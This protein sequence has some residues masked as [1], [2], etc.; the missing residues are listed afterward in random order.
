MRPLYDPRKQE[1]PLADGRLDAAFLR[2]L[3][4]D[5][6]W[7]VRCRRW[8]ANDPYEKTVV[9]RSQLIEVLL[10]DGP[11]YAPVQQGFHHLGLLC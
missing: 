3:A 5:M 6:R 8:K 9:C 4:Y 7:S 10:A 2:A 1:T 11:R